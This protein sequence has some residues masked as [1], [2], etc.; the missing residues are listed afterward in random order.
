MPACPRDTDCSR[1]SIRS[2]RH[3]DSE[4]SSLVS[5]PPHSVGKMSPYDLPQ[6]SIHKTEWQA[7]RSFHQMTPDSLSSSICSFEKSAQPERTSS[8]CSPSSGLA[9][10]TR[11]GVLENF[12]GVPT[13]FRLPCDEKIGTCFLLEQC[14]RETGCV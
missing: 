10:S 12:I 8:V 6:P 4:C 14:T 3:E 2:V 9:F 13:T 7:F 5:I 1:G 11:Q